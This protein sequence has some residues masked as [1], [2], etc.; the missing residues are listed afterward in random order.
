MSDITD[1]AG[2]NWR[3]GLP[4]IDA[5]TSGL[6]R[7]WWALEIRGL[8]AILFGLA[9]L[10]STFTT[11]RVLELVFAAYMLVDGIFAIVAAIRAV[12]RHERWGLLVLEGVIGIFA[13]LL[14]LVIPG[15]A[16]LVF[17]TLVAVWAIVSGALLAASAF[18]LHAAHGRWWM[19]FSGVISIIWG[20]LL[21]LFPAAGAVVLTWWLGGY[22]IV[23]GVMMVVLG[24]RLRRR[25]VTPAP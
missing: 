20:V 15:L 24:L 23:F 16:V 8:I 4:R 13:G 7:N 19:L 6:A 9:A 14:A 11:L 25:H 5:M 22:A 3:P 18:T 2:G 10:F 12:A 17:I 21:W 1:P